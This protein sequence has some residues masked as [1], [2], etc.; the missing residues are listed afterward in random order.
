MKKLILVHLISLIL[1]VFAGQAISIDEASAQQTPEEIIDRGV[2]DVPT[3]SVSCPIQGGRIV[4]SS[5]QD[6]T[7]RGTVGHCTAGYDFKCSCEPGQSRRAKAIDIATDGKEAILPTITGQTVNWKLLTK[8]SVN[9]FEGGGAGYTFEATVGAETWYLDMLHLK[10]TPLISGQSYP[11]GT[12]VAGSVISHVHATIGKNLKGPVSAG[13]SSDCDPGWL[14]SDFMCDSTKQPPTSISQ[15]PAGGATIPTGPSRG[16]SN[17]VCTRVGNPTGPSPCE[18]TSSAI[19]T[20][21]GFV[22]YCQ[23]D[24]QWEKNP[25]CAMSASGCGPTSIAMVLSTLGA[26]CNGGQCTPDVVDKLMAS[27]GQRDASCNS[28][29]RFDVQWFKALGMEAGPNLAPN[30]KFNYEK[31]KEAIDRGALIIGSSA[32]APSCNCNHIFVVQNVDPVSKT[33]QVRDPICKN[34]K[35]VDYNNLYQNIGWLYAYPLTNPSLRVASFEN[36]TSSGDR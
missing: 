34:G 30:G 1:L 23:N 2:S 32:V 21:G 9:A 14:P 25:R 19:L 16:S 27:N 11:S 4:T 22:H 7:A 31:A 26:V 8:Y 18:A 12:A 10:L 15:G 35:E 36:D 5:Y 20:S 13:S 17:K 6:A 24:P 29:I 33:I 28:V 3:P